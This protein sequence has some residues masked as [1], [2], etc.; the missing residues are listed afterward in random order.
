MQRKAD[1]SKAEF[2]FVLEIADPQTHFPTQK[3]GMQIVGGHVGHVQQRKS[4]FTIEGLTREGQQQ[5]EAHRGAVFGARET[6]LWRSQQQEP[7][8]GHGQT[9][10]FQGRR[11][12]QHC[13]K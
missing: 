2:G 5:I 4:R 12:I 8:Q 13:A 10:R 9:I 6:S 11:R 1:G 7:G 3:I